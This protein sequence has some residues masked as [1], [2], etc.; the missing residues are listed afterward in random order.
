MKYKE[1]IKLK[2]MLENNDEIIIDFTFVKKYYGC[3]IHS[4]DF[5]HDTW[6]GWSVIESVMSYG[7]KNDLLEIAGEILT[8]KEK[9]H[10]TGFDVVGSLSAE[11]VY[12]R[13]VEF[14]KRRKSSKVS[15]QK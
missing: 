6:K 4:N 11:N 14:E 7:N 3:Q 5:S 15:L 12:R 13:I 1:I 2:E 9:R 10:L 8:E